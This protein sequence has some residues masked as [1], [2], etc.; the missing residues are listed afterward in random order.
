MSHDSETDAPYGLDAVG[1]ADFLQLLPKVADM[2]VHGFFPDRMAGSPGIFVDLLPRK[3]AARRMAEKQFQDLGFLVG[4]EDFLIAGGHG[5]VVGVQDQVPEHQ[6]VPADSFPVEP[7]EQGIVGKYAA[8]L[9]SPAG[10][11][12]DMAVLSPW[13]NL[14]YGTYYH[15]ESGVASSFLINMH[16]IL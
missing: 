12:L 1:A 11:F 10:I 8:P 14:I 3:D 5:Q 4:E 15:N 2:D 16:A 7:A 9:P 6:D 13:N